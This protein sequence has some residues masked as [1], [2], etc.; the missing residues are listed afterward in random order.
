MKKDVEEAL[1]IMG[2][3]IIPLIL[4]TDILFPIVVFII[5]ALLYIVGGGLLLLGGITLIKSWRKKD[6]NTTGV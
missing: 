3:S 2:F 5:K 1:E 4:T 6:N